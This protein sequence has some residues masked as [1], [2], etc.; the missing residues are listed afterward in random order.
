MIAISWRPQDHSSD[1]LGWSEIDTAIGV[2]LSSGLRRGMLLTGAIIDD[3]GT[4]IGDAIVMVVWVLPPMGHAYCNTVSF[5]WLGT[6]W[7]LANRSLS[8]SIKSVS[9]FPQK[10]RAFTKAF[11]IWNQYWRHS[12]PFWSLDSQSSR[13]RGHFHNGK[14]WVVWLVP[15]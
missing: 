12:R 9:M 7:V 6:Y 4:R 1:D 13:R 11:L 10:A 3:V 5:P 15:G 2:C 8:A 14:H